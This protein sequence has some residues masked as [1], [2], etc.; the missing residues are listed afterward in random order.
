MSWTF[1]SV[2]IDTPYLNVLNQNL[3]ASFRCLEHDARSRQQFVQTLFHILYWL[4]TGVGQSA[5]KSSLVRGQAIATWSVRRMQVSLLR[6]RCAPSCRL[7]RLY[8]GADKP[9]ARPTS[10][11]ILFD[12]ENISFDAS[13]VIYRVSQKERTILRE[14]VP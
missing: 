14:S 7:R 5:L 4:Y 11:C 12:G 9:L 2:V 13:L 8:R 6:L 10:R 1:L 3:L